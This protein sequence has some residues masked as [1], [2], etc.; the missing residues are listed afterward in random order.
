MTTT[1][2]EIEAQAIALSARERGELAY[3]LIASLDGEPLGASK[4][5][6]KA[7]DEEIARR[8]ADMEA[9]NTRWNLADEIMARMRQ[10]LTAAHIRCQSSEATKHKLTPK[11]PSTGTPERR[12][13]GGG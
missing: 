6:A 2:K 1:V 13:Y 9:D 8:L 4:E 11:P 10:K 5:I 7:W 3:R 12:F